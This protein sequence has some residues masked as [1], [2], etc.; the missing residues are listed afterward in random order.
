MQADRAKDVRSC[1]QRCLGEWT[2][3]LGG[4]DGSHSKAL[5]PRDRAFRFLEVLPVSPRPHSAKGFFQIKLVE[6]VSILP[7]ASV[8]VSHLAG[9]SLQAAGLSLPPS[10]RT[11]L[12]TRRVT[13]P[14]SWRAHS[15]LIALQST[16]CSPLSSLLPP[17]PPSKLP[18]WNSFH[19]KAPSCQGT[20]SGLFRFC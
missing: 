1:C 20:P 11:S 6:A 4:E 16:A 15:A 12:P 3:A 13:H 18:L 19:E 10:S 2:T 14:H 7:H 17:A 8:S 9:R 5:R